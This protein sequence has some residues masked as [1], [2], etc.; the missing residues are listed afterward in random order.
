[1]V[2]DND[3][4]GINIVY[5]YGATIS[6]QKPAFP[7]LS[8]GPVSYPTNRPI[9][10]GYED[11]SSGGR[12]LVCGSMRMFDDEF[13]DKE[14]NSKALDGMLRWL[15]KPE[16]SVNDNPG[17]DD[18]SITEYY[19]TPDTSSLSENLR[20]CL[21]ESIELPKD[22]TKLFNQEL[23]RFDTILVPDAVDLFKNMDVK[24]CHITLIPPTFETPMPPL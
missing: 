8:T 6:T 24:H 7:L 5:S 10:S 19:R 11:P 22:F 14:D 16:V 1:M 9:L 4:S 2:C 15:A 20:A 23:F 3:G 13:I 17:R 21:Q 18:N 12:L